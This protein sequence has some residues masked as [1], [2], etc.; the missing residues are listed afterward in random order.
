MLWVYKLPDKGDVYNQTIVV[1]ELSEH[2]RHTKKYISRRRVKHKRTQVKKGWVSIDIKNTVRRWIEKPKKNFGLKISCKTCKRPVDEEPISSENDLKPFVAIKMKK[3]TKRRTKRR[4][5]DCDSGYSKCCRASL[6]VSFSKIK[7]DFI[8]QPAGYNANY[9][10]G[11]CGKHT[12]I[13][14]F[15]TM[16]NQESHKNNY[17]I[18]FKTIS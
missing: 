2:N 13:S 18:T 17:T 4:A 8:T 11:T 5:T 9:C 14:L 10:K 6:Y 1:S 16:F 7:Y 15:E 12:F 3:N